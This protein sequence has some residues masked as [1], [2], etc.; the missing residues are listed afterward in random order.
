MNR[1]GFTLIELLIA[2]ILMTAVGG[3]IYQILLNNQRV[4]QRQTQQV[5]MQNNLR[6]VVG[7]LPADM[8]ELDAGDPLGGDILSMDSNVVRYKATRGLYFLC[9][10][11]DTL[12]LSITVFYGDSLRFPRFVAYPN[13]SRDTLY[14][15]AEGDTTTRTD[16]AWLRAAV[17]SVSYNTN[18]PQGVLPTGAGGYTIGLT[19]LSTAQL[20][21]VEKG[22]PVRSTQIWEVQVYQDALGDW[23]LGA[24]DYYTSGSW[25]TVQPI[26]G[27]LS[28]ASGLKLVYYDSTGA[29]T[30]N[31]SL[32]RRVG[33]T[34]ETR[35]ASRVVTL[36]G[37][38]Y[39]VEDLATQIAL[40]NNPGK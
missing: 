8:R 30:S 29:V 35:S 16:N 22:A 5:D 6:T 33:L 23:W 36:S 37:F 27:P 39:A 4:Y 10:A 20:A 38:D 32:V 40:R 17:S 24:R 2:L 1:R 15:Y 3:A 9:T 21:R 31:R 26:V 7:F 13:I 14:I 12:G 19:G 11:P 25:T 18:C 34:V 28:G